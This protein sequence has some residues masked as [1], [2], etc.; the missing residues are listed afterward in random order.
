MH[1]LLIKTK[2]RDNVYS[3]LAVKI[4]AQHAFEC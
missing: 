1:V 3:I 4:F 2:Y